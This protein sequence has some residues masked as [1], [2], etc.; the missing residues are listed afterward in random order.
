MK[1]STKRR[2]TDGPI[3]KVYYDYDWEGKFVLLIIGKQLNKSDEVEAL[4]SSI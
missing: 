3:C 1:T 2:A 4:P